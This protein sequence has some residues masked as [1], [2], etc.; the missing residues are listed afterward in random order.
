[1]GDASRPDMKPGWIGYDES[2]D[3]LDN[4][5]NDLEKAERKALEQYK[6]VQEEL[7]KAREKGDKWLE[8]K[9]RQRLD[10]AKKDV[11]NVQAEKDNLVNRVNE[12]AQRAVDLQRKIDKGFPDHV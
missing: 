10:Q 5:L 9:W 1:E 2:T 8:E 12:R 7:K 4:R 6:K 3:T 11:G